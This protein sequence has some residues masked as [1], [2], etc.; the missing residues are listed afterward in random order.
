MK[1]WT[2]VA[3]VSLTGALLAGVITFAADQKPPAPAAVVARY[4]EVFPAPKG[5]TPAQ[6]RVEIKDWHFVRDERGIKLPAAGFYIAQLKSGQIDTEI[7]GNKEHRHVGDFWT[8]AAG[9][10]MT[11]HFPAHSQA[12]QIRTIAVGPGK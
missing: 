2:A 8:V 5:T 11:V 3:I 4:S 10:N 12:A 1:N 6:V 9:Q 7:A